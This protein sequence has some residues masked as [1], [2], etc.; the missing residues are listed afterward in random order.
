MKRLI[1][2][3]LAVLVLGSAAPGAQELERLFKAAMNA[4]LVDGDLSRAIEQYKKVAASANR[5]LAAQA[6]VRMAECYQKL[7]NAEAQKIYERV[8]RE[9]ADQ[10]E[11]ALARARLSIAPSEANAGIT[12][13]ALPRSNVVPGTVSPDGRYLTFASWSDGNLY[14]RDLRTGIDRQLTEVVGFNVGLSAIS[15]DATLV[16]YQSYES[17]CDGKGHGAALCLVSVAENKLPVPKAL[18]ASDEI[19]EIAPMAWSPDGRM[20]AVSLRRQDRTAQIGVVAVPDGEIR[21]LQSVDWRGPT[22]IFFSPDGR[23]LVFDLPV[24]DTQRRPVHSHACRE[25]KQVAHRRRASRSEH[26]DGLDTRRVRTALCQRP[27]WNDGPVG[28]ALYGASAN[29]DTSLYPWRP[30]WCVV[31][32]RHEER[33]AVLWRPEARSGHLSN[34]A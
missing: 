2:G 33:R 29:G 23:D 20:I 8:V 15:T 18:V 10:P 30:G 16:A 19:L 3:V 17:G 5:A 12:L 24:S 28:T 25:R 27:R 26:R 9:F 21:V 1:A 6:L 14:L 13:K 32:G 34:D 31:A 22:R 4:E 11:A 7:G